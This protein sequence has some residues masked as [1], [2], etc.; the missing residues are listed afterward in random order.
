MFFFAFFSYPFH[1]FWILLL[2]FINHIILLGITFQRLKSATFLCF[3]LIVAGIYFFYR[4]YLTGRDF[5]QYANSIPN[6]VKDE[7]LK[8][9][10][11]AFFTLSKD[12]YFLFD[13]A[14]Y[15]NSINYYN[16]TIHL[17]KNQE[18]YFNQYQKFILLAEINYKINNF[19]LSSESLIDANYLIPNRYI[20]L[21]GLLKLSEVK[22]D[23]SL[24]R[25]YSHKILVMPIKVPSKIV[26][27]I[28]N[29]AKNSYI[30]INK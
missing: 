18:L 17:I 15:L 8:A 25:H 28:K 9:Y 14:S 20:P 3:Y 7:K 21:A 26:S 6:S 12:Q 24:I 16:R 5:W 4:P 10:N 13:Y 2:F 11:E 1:S 27:E 30:S 19:K 23:T 22:N 29:K